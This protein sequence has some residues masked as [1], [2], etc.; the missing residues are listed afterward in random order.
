VLPL[1]SFDTTLFFIDGYSGKV[2]HLLAQ[3]SQHI[4]DG[5]FSSIWIA[6]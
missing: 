6:E 1:C 2:T 5:A 4:E 3:A